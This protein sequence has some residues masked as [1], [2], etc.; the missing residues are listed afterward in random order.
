MSK[1]PYDVVIATM[2]RPISL[3]NCLAHIESQTEPPHQVIVVDASD[4]PEHGRAVVCG[5]RRSDIKWRHVTAEERNLPRQRNQ[6]LELVRSEVVLLPDDDSMLYPETA[7]NMMAVYREDKDRMVAG[8]S[9]IAAGDPP[10][11]AYSATKTNSRSMKDKLDPVRNKLEERFVRKPFVSYPKSLW[12]E[13]EAPDWVD[14]T[15]FALVPSIG[16]YLLSL[17]S[18]I[19]KEH[20]FDTTLGYG[21]GY[22]LHEDM[23][24]SLRLQQLGYLL[25]AAQNGWIFHDVHPSRRAAGFSYGFCWIANYIYACRRNIPRESQAWRSDLPQF[26]RYKLALYRARAML[27]RDAFS[28]DIYAGARRAWDA[29][30][31]LMTANDHELAQ[32]YREL[33]DQHLRS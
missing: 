24:L 1:V 27:R 26:M 8:V 32:R 11:A 12:K 5:D 19:A 20:Q 7:A 21:M 2:N 16:G 9:G 4:N 17:R 31:V 14:G 6:G 15:T 18:A 23:E 13:R 22:A 33:C 29:R 10:S 28:K 25:V 30:Q 3:S